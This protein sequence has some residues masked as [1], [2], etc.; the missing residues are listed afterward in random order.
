MP[1]RRVASDRAAARIISR[2]KIRGLIDSDYIANVIEAELDRFDKDPG[3]QVV[4]RPWRGACVTTK[5]TMDELLD[6]AG[7][8][9]A[10][11]AARAAA[12]GIARSYA[13]SLSEIE[14][15]EDHVPRIAKIIED[16]VA[17]SAHWDEPKAEVSGTDLD[18][19]NRHRRLLGMPPLDPEAR[20]W[21]PEDV[22]AEARR[23]RRLNPGV[24]WGKLYGMPFRRPDGSIVRM[25]RKRQRVRFYDV[26]GRQVGPE[27]GNVAP[28]F[29][30]AMHRGWQLCSHS[31]PN[32]EHEMGEI[33]RLLPGE[34]AAKAGSHRAW[35]KVVRALGY[36]PQGYY[37]LQ[38]RS[39]AGTSFFFVPSADF[40]KIR[41]IKGVSKWRMKSGERW[42]K[43][44]RFG[45][46]NP[47]D[48]HATKARMLRWS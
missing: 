21:M 37:S 41:K 24:S 36:R 3:A 9:G 6:L 25:Y 32:P 4:E 7:S 30:Y 31:V 40:E 13:T 16:Q 28:A 20:G 12:I 5:L 43:T 19:I 39:S 23:I 34:V 14:P 42:A 44:I 45:R 22:E 18:V 29:A 10:R 11:P 2:Y 27:Q 48:I 1:I 33:V 17:R 46:E 47:G 26:D 15:P 38:R 8:S 35:D